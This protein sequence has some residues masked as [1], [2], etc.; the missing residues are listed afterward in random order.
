MKGAI[1]TGAAGGLGTALCGAFRRAGYRVVATDRA[2]RKRPSAQFVEADL[3]EA[4]ASA[5]SLR[6]FAERLRAALDGAR[7]KALVH[8]AALQVR[9]GVDD[10]TLEDWNRTLGVN[11]TAPLF[12]TRALLPELERARGL[13]VNVG[14][15]HA[16]ATKPRF[17]A[18]ATSKAALEG[19]TRAMAVD[20]GP[21]VRI[22]AV[23]PAAIETP[24]LRSGFAGNRQL[25]REL[26]AAHPLERIADP[27]EIARFVLS[28]AEG[29]A[30]F[31]TG[32]AFVL[33]G[34][35]LSRLHDPE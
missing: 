26:A 30:A 27:G 32:S 20:L 29:N 34:G 6:Q 14:S 31:A 3:L 19:L 35:V 2:R 24:M 1:I 10:V 5:T 4:C 23:H 11:L 25:L 33:D 8:C 13:V 16:R 28:L 22:L 12:L 17:V 18:Y 21:R 9:A 7:L 15:V